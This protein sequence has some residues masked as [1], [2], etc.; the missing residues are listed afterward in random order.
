MFG[1]DDD[2][3]DDEMSKK[4]KSRAQTPSGKLDEVSQGKRQ[5]VLNAQQ[6]KALPT[7]AVAP[8]STKNMFGALPVSH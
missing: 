3:E 7:K 2:D 8:V 6:A 4:N 5:R 1:V